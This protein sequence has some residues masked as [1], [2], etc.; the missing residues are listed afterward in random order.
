MVLDSETYDTAAH[1]IG[2]KDKLVQIG[3]VTGDQKEK[4]FEEAQKVAEKFVREL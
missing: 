1:L 3:P 4:I 2:K